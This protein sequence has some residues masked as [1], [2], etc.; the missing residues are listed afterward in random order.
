MTYPPVTQ[1]ETR[2]RRA[3]AQARLTR[4][5]RA[6]CTPKHATDRSRRLRIWLALPRPRARAAER[7][8]SLKLKL[9][10]CER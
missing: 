6:A 7:T 9:S 8:P 1:F 3:E 2:A 10:D 4:E 5:R